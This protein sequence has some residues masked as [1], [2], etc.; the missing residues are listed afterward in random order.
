MQTWPNQRLGKPEC[1]QCV[2]APYMEA[3]SCKWKQGFN[4]Q[5]S[6]RSFCTL[7]E[8]GMHRLWA[9]WAGQLQV[10]ADQNWQETQSSS[11][12]ERTKTFS[13]E[14]NCG[15]VLMR[16]KYKIPGSGP[17]RKGEYEI[18]TL[19]ERQRN[20]ERTGYGHWRSRHLASWWVP[21]AK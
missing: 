10:G 8:N 7:T 2:C 3:R 11:P 12:K 15:S 17:E 21:K 1:D 16:W 13:S 19:G 14:L 6:S 9:V 5:T 20:G 18:E 4:K